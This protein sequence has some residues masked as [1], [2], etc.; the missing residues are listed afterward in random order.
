MPEEKSPSVRMLLAKGRPK[1]L[2]TVA[3]MPLPPPPPEPP[4][5]TPM[6]APPESAA[7]PANPPLPPPPPSDCATM[8]DE[9]APLVTSVHPDPYPVTD[10]FWPPPSAL[11]VALMASWPDPP[12]PPTPTDTAPPMPTPA[13]TAKP[14]LPPP[15]P[16]RLGENAVEL[17]SE[18]SI[19]A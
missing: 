11:T 9:L 7:V 4:T 18:V 5:D 15:P 6:L 14:P 19:D 13:A 16:T 2:L 12:P 3:S 17:A 8:P 10:R 1:P